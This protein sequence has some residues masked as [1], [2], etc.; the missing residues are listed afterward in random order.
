[1]EP[2]PEQRGACPRRERDD[3]GVRILATYRGTDQGSK[4]MKH[5]GSSVPNCGRRSHKYKGDM[6]V[7]KSMKTVE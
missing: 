1:M 6:L 5:R 3:G 4:H 2:E 7:P